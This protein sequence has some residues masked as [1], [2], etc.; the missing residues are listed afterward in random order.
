MGRPPRTRDRGSPGLS[1]ACADRTPGGRA[2]G[3]G[4]ILEKPRPKPSTWVRAWVGLAGAQPPST[5][6]RGLHAP[7]ARVRLWA[8]S[9]QLQIGKNKSIGIVWPSRDGTCPGRSKGKGDRRKYAGME[10]RE[11]AG[12]PQHVSDGTSMVLVPGAWVRAGAPHLARPPPQSCPSAPCLL[13]PA[14]CS[15]S[16]LPT[17][18]L[19]QTLCLHVRSG[20]T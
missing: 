7:G 3:R 14:H 17:G 19:Q 11:P 13:G 4:A 10:M 1:P 15:A 12:S 20:C 8:F 18:R 9:E 2:G 5:S 16:F 6:H